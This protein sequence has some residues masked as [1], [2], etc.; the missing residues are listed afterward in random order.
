M[1]LLRVTVANTKECVCVDN[2]TTMNCEM[3]AKH[4]EI[5]PANRTAATTRLP[6]LAECS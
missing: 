2:I 3:I 6:A 1:M 4:L 5:S